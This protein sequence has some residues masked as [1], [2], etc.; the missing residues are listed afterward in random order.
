MDLE[1]VGNLLVFFQ[2]LS[3][4]FVFIFII[5][6]YLISAKGSKYKP[7]VKIVFT[8][9]VMLLLSLSSLTL[10]ENKQNEMIRFEFKSKLSNPI[11]T[12][13]V[14]INGKQINPYKL[15]PLLLSVENNDIKKQT[16]N[17]NIGFSVEI[18]DSHQITRYLYIYKSHGENSNWVIFSRNKLTS[19]SESTYI[20][21]IADGNGVLNE[22][23]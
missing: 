2:F 14:K 6:M 7:S 16:T 5:A 8:M 18:I 9:F 4:L 22:Y 3:F 12:Y 17:T 11:Y 19:Y 13:S 23:K 21:P 1:L 10:L 15:I 20:G